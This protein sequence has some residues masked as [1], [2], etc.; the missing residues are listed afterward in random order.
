M[1]CPY[2]AEEIKDEA[3]VC[4]YCGHDFSLVKPLLARLISLERQFA[5]AGDAASQNRADL[6]TS[7]L[8]AAFLAVALGTLYTSGYLLVAIAPPPPSASW[9]YVFAITVP[10]ALLGALLGVLWSRRTTRGYL[11]SGFSLGILNLIF[12]WLILSTFEGGKIGLSLVLLTFGLGQPLTFAAFAYLANTLRE[13]WAPGPVRPQGGSGGGKG[14][15]K[16]P[17]VVDL[18]K[19]AVTL[20]GTIVAAIQLLKGMMP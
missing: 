16:F 14:S 9:P 20:A 3:V 11:L 19:A 13:R 17:L 2:C 4:R 7:P 18:L 8:L 15:A 10:P 5:A 1:N 6:A 12:I